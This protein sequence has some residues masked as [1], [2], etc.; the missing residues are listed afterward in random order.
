M[1]DLSPRL[2]LPYL[3]PSQAQKHVTH[4]E[5]LRLLDS[6]VQLTLAGIG[7]LAPPLVPTEGEAWGLGDE[8]TGAWSG[9]DG[10]IAI[11][12]D[13]AWAFLEPVAGWRAWDG[14]AAE[15]RVY[16][17]ASWVL[18]LAADPELQNLPLLGIGATADTVNRLAVAS[19][20]VLLSHAGADHRLTVNKAGAGDTGSVLF[21]SGWSGRAEMGLAGSD[22]FSVKVSADGGT[23][24]EGL[25]IDAASGALLPAAGLRFPAV[26]APVAEANTLDCYAEGS[27]SPG[28]SAATSAP[29]GGSI[30]AS[31]SFVKIGR[32]VWLSFE[33]T[34]AD[35]GSGGA[36]TLQIT[37][38]PFALGSG[39]S[40]ALSHPGLSLPGSGGPLLS[41]SG[42]TALI[43]ASDG[44]PLDWS[45][46]PS[47]G[48]SLSGSAGG[49]AL[50]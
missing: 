40:A 29:S 42:T 1:P 41:L 6:L 44:T 2:G 4:N 47:G 35:K 15:L 33:I 13:G 21:Q 38:L 17:G 37:G 32:M 10:E 20:A 11:W 43:G 28:L 19:E 8:P 36:G 7:A 12:S 5:A 24:R 26:P 9:H 18:P 3:M 27:W 45:A 49:L 14:G 50:D 46:V 31:G 22:D 39:W 30:T 48:L 34:V 16:D 23:W 25:R